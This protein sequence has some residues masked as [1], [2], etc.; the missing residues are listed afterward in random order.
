MRTMP[1]GID[2]GFSKGARM[3]DKLD[4]LKGKG[5]AMRVLPQKALNKKT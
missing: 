3:E 2:F 5:K 4:L 1:H